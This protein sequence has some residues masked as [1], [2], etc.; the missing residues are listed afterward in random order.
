MRCTENCAVY[1][2][3]FPTATRPWWSTESPFPLHSG[4]AT[5]MNM[6]DREYVRFP[7]AQPVDHSQ[8]VRGAARQ[9]DPQQGTGN[10]VQ[11]SR[12]NAPTVQ[13]PLSWA[14]M[15]NRH[16]ALR[17]FR[18][19]YS[20]RDRRFGGHLRRTGVSTYSNSRPPALSKTSRPAS[21]ETS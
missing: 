18:K 12:Q 1:S 4:Q 19:I 3:A 8:P 7:W 10:S 13:M 15:T 17:E 21:T 20:S 2:R 6:G 5:L 14:E 16:A 11:P 9:S